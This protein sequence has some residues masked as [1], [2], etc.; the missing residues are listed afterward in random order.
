MQSPNGNR[1]GEDLNILSPIAG[2]VLVASLSA[3]AYFVWIGRVIPVC[4]SKDAEE[5]KVVYIKGGLLEVSS[6]RAPEQF[7]AS[8]DET[9]L[10][11]SVGKTIS[12]IKV[13]AVYRYHVELDPQWKVILKDKTFIVISPPVKPS[14]PVAIDTAKLEA[15]ASG[16]WSL[17]TGESRKMELQKSIT[18]TLEA[19]ASS[20]SYINFQRETARRTLKD[21]V[22]KWLVT[23]EQWKAAATY[24]IQV[25]FADEPIQTLKAVPQPFA[26]AL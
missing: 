5:T 2:L 23:Q 10:G 11:V 25:Y 19:K 21:F 26:G 16:R 20:P 18:K 4:T 3:N 8:T 13:P 17:L 24:P 14:L 22:A 1:K 6:I 9:I 12:R 15:E 7:D